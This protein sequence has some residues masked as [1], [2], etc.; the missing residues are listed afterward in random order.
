[1][2][3]LQNEILTSIQN[4]WFVALLFLMTVIEIVP[5]RINPWTR[6]FK[7]IGRAMNGEIMIEVK[8]LRDEVSSLRKEIDEDKANA[9]RTR[10][11]RFYDELAH[12][13]KHSKEHFDQTLIDI[14]TYE[15]FC[16]NHPDF[17]NNI[18]CMAIKRIK[19]T[20]DQCGKDN[21]FL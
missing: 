11:L 19:D 3:T 13:I 4:V 18:A 6:I 9:C 10:I 12:D 21:T 7:L 2:L 14:N 5:L 1:M 15:A 16:D 8:E 20:Y 17:K